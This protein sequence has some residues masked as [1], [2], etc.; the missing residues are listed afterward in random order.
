MDLEDPGVAL[1]TWR[2]YLRL[3]AQLNLPRG[4]RSKLDASDIVQQTMMQAHQTFTQF[5]G[6]SEA[7]LRGWLRRIL[8][9]NL[10]HASRDYGRAKRDLAR[11]HSIEAALD[12]SSARV[13]VW[14]AANQSSPSLRVAHEEQVTRLADALTHLPD[15]QREVVMLHYWQGWTIAAIARHMSRS[16]SAV[17]GLLK[18]GLRKLRHELQ[19][20]DI[21]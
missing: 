15:A 19:E 20:S 18:R 9:R 21:L 1:E 2:P 13:D 7:E 4:L 5:R 14:L 17:A 3:L 11:E 10:I 16:S 6:Q 12:A 8:A